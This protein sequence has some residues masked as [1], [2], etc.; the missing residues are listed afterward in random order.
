MPE[1]GVACANLRETV[2]AEPTGDGAGLAQKS[3]LDMHLSG[4]SCL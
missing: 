2:P 3:A 1:Q 4:S